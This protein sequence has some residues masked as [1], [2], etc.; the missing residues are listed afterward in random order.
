[1]TPQCTGFHFHAPPL[2]T[3]NRFAVDALRFTKEVFFFA[4]DNN[5]LPSLACCF[6]VDVLR[7]TKGVFSFADDDNICPSLACCFAVDAFRFTKGVFGFASDD[8]TC[9]SLAL[10][11]RLETELHGL[12]MA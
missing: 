5:I 7:F 2:P 3:S 4:D 6:A 11:S 1:M 9:S 10:S 12:T 8:N